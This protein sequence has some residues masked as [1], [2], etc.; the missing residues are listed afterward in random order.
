M[1]HILEQT[2][3]HVVHFFIEAEEKKDN[4]RPLVFH[5]VPPYVHEISEQ[6]PG[7][8]CDIIDP[9]ESHI[10]PESESI[11]GRKIR[12]YQGGAVEG[13]E[14]ELPFHGI[15]SPSTGTG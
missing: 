12:F 15:S 4:A 1:L 11:K 6:S 10:D 2:V 7:T 14:N 13:T 3:I 5:A 9:Y 8:G